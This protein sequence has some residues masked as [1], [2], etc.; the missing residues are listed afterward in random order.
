MRI[1]R[2]HIHAKAGRLL[3]AWQHRD[4]A[5]VAFLVLP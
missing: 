5:I 3:F 4:G 2:L 1:Y